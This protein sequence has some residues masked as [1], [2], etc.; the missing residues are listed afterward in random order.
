MKNS[1]TNKTTLSMIGFFIKLNPLYGDEPY[2]SILKE[3]KGCFKEKLT[4]K[5]EKIG[6]CSLLLFNIKNNI[7]YVDIFDAIDF[8]FSAPIAVKFDKT[9]F[10]DNDH[11]YY[12]GNKKLN[13]ETIYNDYPCNT[14]IFTTDDVLINYF[15]K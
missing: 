11:E 2:F 9:F 7:D 6:D 14:A 15:I 1:E 12:I 5:N 3:F 13:K 10:T 8:N 4:V